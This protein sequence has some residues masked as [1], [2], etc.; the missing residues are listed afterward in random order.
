MTK[1]AEGRFYQDV[2]FRSEKDDW[3]TPYKL[4]ELLDSYYDFECDVCADDEN[5][6]CDNYFTK[7]FSC[8]TNDWYC[9]NYMKG[10]EH[11]FLLI[12]LVTLYFGPGTLGALFLFEKEFFRNGNT[13]SSHYSLRLCL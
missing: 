8:L 10:R 5:A 11:V 1:K 2:A 7:E 12:I 6:L 9:F 4:F 13:E 3:H